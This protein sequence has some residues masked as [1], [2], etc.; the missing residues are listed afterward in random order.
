MQKSRQYHHQSADRNTGYFHSY[1]NFRKRRNHIDALQ[2][3]LGLWRNDTNSIDQLLHSHSSSVT[4]TT[5]PQR[6][7][8]LLNLITPCITDQENKQLLTIPSVEEVKEVL[9]MMKPWT[10]PGCDGFQAVF[11]YQEA[12]PTVGDSVVSIV[13]HFFESKYILTEMNH[14][15]QVLIPKIPD[16]TQ[17]A[18]FRPISLFNIS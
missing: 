18:D 17:H 16:P 15:Y 12:W 1:A 3:N 5:H 11:F 4:C 6:N 2:D 7:Q 14:T 10:A 13:Q 8:H 9:F